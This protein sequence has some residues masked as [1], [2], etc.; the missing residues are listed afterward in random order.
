MSFAG[1]EDPELCNY[2]WGLSDIISFDSEMAMH[3]TG[4]LINIAYRYGRPMFCTNWKASGYTFFSDW[5]KYSLPA[6]VRHGC[7]ITI[8]K[9][10]YN[11]LVSHFG[12]DPKN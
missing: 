1:S 5:D 6:S 7:M 4:W 12:I 11:K 2:I 8:S 10:E 9:D 3:E